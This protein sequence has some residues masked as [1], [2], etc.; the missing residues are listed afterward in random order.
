MSGYGEV[1]KALSAMA[2]ITSYSPREHEDIKLCQHV[3]KQTS[4]HSVSTVISTVQP[5]YLS[6]QLVNQNSETSL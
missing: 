5:K 4:P 6:W 3:M 1:L 2:S